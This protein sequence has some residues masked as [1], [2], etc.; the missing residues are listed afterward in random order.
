M[1][2]IGFLERFNIKS[3]AGWVPVEFKGQE[4]RVDFNQSQVTTIVSAT[5]ERPDLGGNGCGFSCPFPAELLNT[6]HVTVSVFCQDYEIT[7]SP[8]EVVTNPAELNKVLYGKEGWLFLTNDTNESLGYLTG[9]RAVNQDIITAW[10]ERIKR[11]EALCHQYGIQCIHLLVPEK[12]VVYRQY[13]PDGLTI[14]PDRPATRLMAALTEAG[15][16]NVIYPDYD[17]CSIKNNQLVYSKGDTHW[18]YDGAY[19]AVEELYKQ[20]ASSLKIQL[21]PK[22]AYTFKASFQASDLL[23]KTTSINV[24][25]VNFTGSVSKKI[26][27]TFHNEINGSG[28]RIEYVNLDLPKTRLMSWHTSSVDWTIPYLNDM[29]GNTCFVWS[30]SI[31][32]NEVLRYRPDVLLIQSNERFLTKVPVDTP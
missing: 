24:E 6:G 30:S 1:A 29:F 20:I 5:I 8:R 23:I 14:A 4:I 16:T 27:R 15:I 26:R 9:H 3:I 25:R 19:F 10:I 32:W 13:L 28:R 18:T 21:I 12:E 31:D 11:I 22:S 17:Q 2:K 7:N